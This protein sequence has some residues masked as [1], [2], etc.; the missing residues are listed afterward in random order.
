MWVLSAVFLL[1]TPWTGLLA[2][3]GLLCSTLTVAL[4]AAASVLTGGMTTLF[5]LGLLGGSSN[6]AEQ[7]KARRRLGFALESARYSVRGAYDQAVLSARRGL[8]ESPDDAL[9]QISLAIALSTRCDPEAFA[10]TESLVK[11]ELAPGP[12]A[13]NV[14]A[15]T[16]YVRYDDALRAEADEASKEALKLDPNNASLLDTRGHVALWHGRLT[17]EEDVLT[18]AYNT[19]HAGATRGSAAAGLRKSRSAAN[20]SPG[21]TPP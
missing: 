2:A 19:K 8:D 17:E 16:C 9:L 15:W 18:R 10:L 1:A 6:T 11:R 14:R 20:S 7:L 13:L 5:V 4:G 3:S 21:R 12:R